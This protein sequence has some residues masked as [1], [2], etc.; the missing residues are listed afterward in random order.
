MEELFDEFKPAFLANAGYRFRNREQFWP[1][2]AHNHL[3]LK[4]D[5]ARVVKPGNTAH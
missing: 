4:S 2:S 5:R 1:I 3:L